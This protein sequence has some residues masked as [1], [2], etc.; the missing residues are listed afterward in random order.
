MKLCKCAEAFG[1]GERDFAASEAETQYGNSIKLKSFS[2]FRKFFNFVEF[3]YWVSA[4]LVAKSSL[5][6]LKASTHLH[7]RIL[8]KPKASAHLRD[9]MLQKTKASAH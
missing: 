5:Q 2:E 1:F 3:P 7:D 4:S 6:K 8:R 9:L